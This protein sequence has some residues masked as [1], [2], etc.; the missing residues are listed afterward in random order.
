MRTR[1]RGS[2][3]SGPVRR[4]GPRP[5]RSLVTVVLPLA[6]GACASTQWPA[7]LKSDSAVAPSS[8]ADYLLRALTVDASG[9]EAMW[10]AAE[11][12][13]AGESATL[14][15]ALLRSIPGTSLY[16]PN[17]A[18]TALED[19]VAHNPSPDVALVARARIEDL[20]AINACRGDVENLKRRLSKVADIEKRLDRERH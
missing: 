17:A 8:P 6:L 14:H 4:R 12:E 3:L 10:Q 15:R 11:H 16:D 18:Q 2:G 9:R 5:M 20:H 19:L 1:V 13:S 7:F